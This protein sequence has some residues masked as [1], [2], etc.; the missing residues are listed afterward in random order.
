MADGKKKK[1][2]RRQGPSKRVLSVFFKRQKSK[3]IQ[4]HFLMILQL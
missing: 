4:K 3:N 1:I 2:L